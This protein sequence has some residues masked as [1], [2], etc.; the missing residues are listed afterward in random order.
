MSRPDPVSAALVLGQQL[1]KGVVYRLDLLELE[2]REEQIRF[3]RYL[4]ATAIG[5]FLLFLSVLLANIALVLTLWEVFGHGL[6]WGLAVFYGLLGIAFSGYVW[7][8]LL[9][10]DGP[11]SASLGELRKDFGALRAK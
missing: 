1:L 5:L 6:L 9:N 4:T 11:F 7:F 8:K 2:L 10:S 3:L